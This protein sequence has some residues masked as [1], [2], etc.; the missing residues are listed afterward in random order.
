[1]KPI[2]AKSKMKSLYFLLLMIVSISACKKDAL[3]VKQEKEFIQVTL[4]PATDLAG[5]GIDLIL[6]PDGTANINPGG[7]I[8]WSATYDISGKKITVTVQQ[9]NSKYKFTVISDEEIHGDG[10]EILKLAKPYLAQ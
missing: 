6:K 2:A 10:G 3:E 1:M 8:V 5:G 9:T 4:Q 7:D